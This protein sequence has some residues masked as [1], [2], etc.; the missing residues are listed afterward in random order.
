MFA[1]RL[2]PSGWALEGLACRM[3]GLSPALRIH[4]PSDPTCAPTASS[5]QDENGM[6]ET[7]LVRALLQL[8]N[9]A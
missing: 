4:A 1:V 7:R 5:R 6:V 8:Q 3:F 2:S 9:L